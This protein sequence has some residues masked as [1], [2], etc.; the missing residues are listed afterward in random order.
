M[1]DE[2]FEKLKDYMYTLIIVA[3]IFLVIAAAGG[4]PIGFGPR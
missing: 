3:V 1:P 4:T 2:P